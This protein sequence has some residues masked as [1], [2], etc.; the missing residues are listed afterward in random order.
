MAIIYGQ[1][2]NIITP[3]GEGNCTNRL[4]GCL[5]GGQA[6]IIAEV[7]ITVDDTA[8]VALPLPVGPPIAAGCFIQVE[9]PTATPSSPTSDDTRVIK[10]TEVAGGDPSNAAEGLYMAQFGA[11]EVNGGV[12]LT[13]FLAR[14]FQAGQT[15]NLRLK[16]YK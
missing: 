3:T 14:G 5:L 16:F 6:I 15:V 8:N 10:Y 2:E 13:N 7:V 12:N 9:N 11:F 1:D 4:L